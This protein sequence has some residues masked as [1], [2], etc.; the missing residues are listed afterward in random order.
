MKKQGKMAQSMEEN[1]SLEANPKEMEIC[2]LPDREFKIL[3]LKK[4]NNLQK[5]TDKQLNESGNN[6]WCKMR[7]STKK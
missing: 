2:E 1:K 4:L 5:N 6:A 7:I 3:V